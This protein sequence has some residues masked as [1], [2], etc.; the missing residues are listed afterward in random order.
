VSERAQEKSF[1]RP[2]SL[3]FFRFLAEPQRRRFGVFALSQ[4]FAKIHELA[5]S[6]TR[7]LSRARLLAETFHFN[8]IRRRRRR[9]ERRRRRRQ[10]QQQQQRRRRR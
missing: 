5:H 7:S 6:L 2:F 9:R 1:S 3:P 4:N 8:R 10:Q